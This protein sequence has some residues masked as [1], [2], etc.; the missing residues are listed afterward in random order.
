MRTTAV[1]RDRRCMD[2]NRFAVVPGTQLG[3]RF[4]WLVTVPTGA[5]LAP[6]GLPALGHNHL[7]TQMVIAALL[8]SVGLVSVLGY[9]WLTG[10]VVRL[11]PYL[12]LAVAAAV[13]APATIDLALAMAREPDG[14][15]IAILPVSLGFLL[16]FIAFGCGLTSFVRV[17]AA[18]RTRA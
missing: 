18:R 16:P 5:A 1:V 14:A 17:S 13:F 12:P 3:N 15:F 7:V 8:P 9:R 2:R 6:W 4:W 10:D 11:V